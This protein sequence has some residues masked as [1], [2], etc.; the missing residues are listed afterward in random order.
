MK[1]AKPE[2]QIVQACDCVRYRYFFFAL[3]RLGSPLRGVDA[4]SC[5]WPFD[6]L[7]RLLF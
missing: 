2:I 4:K 6:I 7:A 3:T 5:N 1:T